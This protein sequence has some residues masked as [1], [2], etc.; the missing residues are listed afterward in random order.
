[1]NLMRD[2]LQTPE[3][4]TDMLKHYQ[5]QHETQRQQDTHRPRKVVVCSCYRHR[6]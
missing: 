6:C 3:S 2:Y 4:P 5:R 1:M